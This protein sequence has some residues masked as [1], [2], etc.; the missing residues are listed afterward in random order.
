MATIIQE[1]AS[2]TKGIS[3]ISRL[4]RFPQP[5]KHAMLLPSLRLLMH[6]CH[7]ITT[8]FASGV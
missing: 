8:R 4:L 3:G 6:L 7:V 2:V 5:I 1:P